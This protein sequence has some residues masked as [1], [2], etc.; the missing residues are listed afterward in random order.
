VISRSLFGATA[1]F[2]IGLLRECAPRIFPIWTRTELLTKRPFCALV[3]LFGIC[4]SVP[5]DA[6]SPQDPAEAHVAI[7]GS[8]TVVNHHFGGRATLGVNVILFGATPS[9][10]YPSP[11]YPA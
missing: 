6:I 4:R 3:E 1:G 11:V 9:C 8:A 2:D 10:R 5:L 7:L